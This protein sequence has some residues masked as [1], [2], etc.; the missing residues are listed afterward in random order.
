LSREEIKSYQLTTDEKLKN[1]IERKASSSA[2]ESDALE[3]WSESGLGIE[4][5]KKL[6]RKFSSFR[7]GYLAI[8]L[9][10]FVPITLIVLFFILPDEEKV[11]PIEK[12]LENRALVQIEKTDLIVPEKIEVMIE[13]PLKEQIQVKQVIKDFKE[14]QEIKPESLQTEPVGQL[15]TKPI[16]E[17]VDRKPEKELLFG[18]EIYLKDLKVLDYRSYR[19]KPSISVEQLILT[20]TPADKSEKQQNAEEEFTW[21]TIDIPYIDYLEKSMDLFSK[22]NN[23]KALTRYEEVLKVYPDD[24]NALFYAGLCY[25]NL[26]DYSKAADYFLKCQLNTFANFNEEAQWYRARSV[27][28]S[29]NKEKAKELLREIV[30]LKGYYSKQAEKLLKN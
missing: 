30:D 11:N 7:K 18:K 1:S 2:F 25:Y 28:A 26:K 29:G 15:N 4:S 19:S 10:T 9:L 8:A 22:G 12:E 6:D 24:I 20:G 16:E 27:L 23:K 13:L 3:G 21:K 17:S 14:Q 5:M